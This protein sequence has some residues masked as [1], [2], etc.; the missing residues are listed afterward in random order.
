M[1]VAR[2][3]LCNAGLV[4]T[5]PK[6]SSIPALNPIN[7]S[8]QSISHCQIYFLRSISSHTTPLAQLL[9]LE[10]PNHISFVSNLDATHPNSS[11]ST[12][13]SKQQ[14]LKNGQH[15]FLLSFYLLILCH[16]MGSDA[17]T[18]HFF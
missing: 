5:E 17:S 8:V 1:E 14:S 9:I 10:F 6:Y 11:P 15:E 12:Y 16:F 18:V 7:E 2:H 4:A 3:T 13:P